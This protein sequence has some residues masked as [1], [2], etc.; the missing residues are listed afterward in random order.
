MG[1]MITLLTSSYVCF[2]YITR[3]VFAEVENGDNG[4]AR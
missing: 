2:R 1:A 3:Q 4:G